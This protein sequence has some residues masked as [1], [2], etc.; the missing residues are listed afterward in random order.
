L[1]LASLFSGG[2]DSTYA[3]YKAKQDGH[4]IECLI[5][6]F[7]KSDESHLLHYPNISATSLQAK[8]MKIPQIVTRIN[9]TD[10]QIEL[11]EL[12]NLLK[13]AKKDFG[14]EGIIH[15]GLF[16][17]YQRI[18]FETLGNNLNL[19]VVS[20]LWNID[21]KNYLKELLDSKFKFIMTSVTSAG[22]DETW[23]GREITMPDVEK[24]ERLSSKHGFNLTF[25]GGEAETFVL[26][27]PLFSSP[28]VIM[29]ANKIWDG[30]RGRFEITE[31]VL[32]K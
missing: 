2:K 20:P 9:S 27:C 23:L 3:M 13:Q 21:Q 6:A 8:S 1:K 16:S 7:P 18:R 17:D 30:Y 29:K 11:E 4:S 5:S 32:E 12:Q 14:I 24:L 25:E 26:D 31:A 10:P 15:G 22:L 28:I 19:K